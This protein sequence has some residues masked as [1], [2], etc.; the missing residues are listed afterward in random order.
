MVDDGGSDAHWLLALPDFIVGGNSVP[1]FVHVEAEG[2]QQAE[3]VDEAVKVLIWA[4]HAVQV[5]FTGCFAD[6][7]GKLLLVYAKGFAQLRNLTGQ[8]FLPRH[9]VGARSG[10]AGDGASGHESLGREVPVET[11]HFFLKGDGEPGTVSDELVG[12]D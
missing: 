6:Q 4:A 2:G 12:L 8:A 11:G 9:K 1:N 5:E 7:A 10:H 3:V